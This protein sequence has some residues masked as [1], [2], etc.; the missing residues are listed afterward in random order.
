M[1]KVELRRL[2]LHAR[3]HEDQGVTPMVRRIIAL[4]C[5]EALVEVARAGVLMGLRAEP[6][7]GTAHHTLAPLFISASQSGQQVRKS[8]AHFSTGCY[9]F[10]ACQWR[11]IA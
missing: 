7:A 1:D 3:R 11:G 4:E 5:A 2:T 9:D 8:P 10:G 6:F